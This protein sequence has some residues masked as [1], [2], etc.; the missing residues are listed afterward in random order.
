MVEWEG[1][2]LVGGL[3]W[4]TGDRRLHDAFRRFCRIVDAEVTM[5]KETGR[6]RGFGFVTFDSQQAIDN[7]IR[8]MHFQELDGRIIEVY[9]YH[10]ETW[11]N[12]RAANTGDAR[13]GSSHGGPGGRRHYHRGRG[14]T[15]F[16]G[17]C[18]ACGLHGHRAQD[19]H[20]NASGG[21]SDGFSPNFYIGDH[22]DGGR[23]GYHWYVGR[24][25]RHD[26]RASNQYPSRGHFD[27]NRYGGGPSRYARQSDHRMVRGRSGEIDE[28]RVRFEVHFSL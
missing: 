24:K 8:E 3:A 7:A 6:S 14:V 23:D 4:Q 26:R 25:G 27:A 5:E 18:F 13:Y 21:S 2:I 12:R 20:N 9:E 17:I 22:Y 19:C 16:P 10:A 11:M 1:R 28:V 15:P